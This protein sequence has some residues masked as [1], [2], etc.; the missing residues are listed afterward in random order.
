MASDDSPLAPDGI[1]R[2]LAARRPD[3]LLDALFGPEAHRELRALYRQGRRR[4]GG[5]RVLILPGIMGSTL[6]TR[7]EGRTDT[8]WF[9]PVEIALGRLTRLA[10]PS[11]RRIEPLGVLA[12]TYQRLKLAL[13]A[14]GFDADFHPYD[15]RHSVT[16]AAD[17]LASRLAR[18]AHAR[19]HLV[20]HSLGGLVAR[21][22]LAHPESAAPGRVVLLGTPNGGAYAA[23]QALWGTYPLVRRLARLD[24]AHGPEQLARKVFVTLPGLA[25]LLPVAGDCVDFDPHAAGDWPPGPRPLAALLARARATRLALPAPDGRF[26]LIAGT[27]RDTPTGLR[28]RGDVLEFRRGPEGD[29]TVPLAL[30]R[31]PGLATWYCEAEHGRL[32]SD[33]RVTRATIEILGRGTTRLLPRQPRAARRRARW[34]PDL[35]P[36]PEPKLFWEDLT[37]EERREFLHEFDAPEEPPPQASAGQA[38]AASTPRDAAR[39]AIGFSVGDIADERSEAIVLGLFEN[40][41]PAGAALAVDQRLGGAIAA[42]ARRRALSAQAGG[43]FMLPAGG[44]RLRAG[45]VVFAGLGDFA[46]YGAE[47]QRLAAA[48]VARTLA[49]AGIR[50]YALVLWGTA[51]G[52]AP[53]EAA[54]AQLLGLLEALADIEPDVWPRRVPLVSRSA[55]RLAAA[56]AAMATALARQP[57][58]PAGEL[59]PLPA[60]AARKA[61][62]AAP[63]VTPLS[64]LFVHEQSGELRAALL[65]PTAKG[66]ALAASRKLDPPALS[67]H[68]ATLGEGIG[69]ARVAAFGE[70]LGEL[71]LPAPMRE[72]L[73]TLRET[74]LVIVHDAPASRW[75][76]ETLHVDGWS[77]AAG[78]GLSRRY[79]A[80]GLSVAKWR[81]ERRLD[82]TLPLLLVVNPTGDLAGADEEGARVREL[83][84]R[85]GEAQLTVLARGQATRARLLEAFRSGDY[86]AIHFAGH[87]YFDA[88]APAASGVLC[89]GGR[90]LSGADLAALDAAPALVVF[91]ACESGRVRG[92]TPV[93]R[94]VGRSAGLA[95][96][97]LRGGVGNFV[98]TWWPVSDDAAARFADRL[99]QDLL[100]GRT[101]GAAV[102][103]ARAAV[104]AGRSGDWANY[105]HY[106]GHDFSLKHRERRPGKRRARTR[107]DST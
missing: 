14:A 80:E 76:W 66:T 99:Y 32:P 11:T 29:G 41:D 3:T 49:L 48:N 22:L 88:L 24:L 8:L 47:V 58:A 25:E 101:L 94:S 86:D 107:G 78:A 19:T 56:R 20:A 106:G 53:A 5:E 100:A 72:A 70:R 91:N 18:E 96:A 73:A 82:R 104:R 75:P 10:L 28:R 93:S 64:Y 59:G 74:P 31:W 6:G 89:A 92:G 40:V 60:P 87:A 33:D 71:L 79:A 95:E 83:F 67:R 37:D 52:I 46:R 77:P 15:W 98:G 27:G 12:F 16:E 42:L 34:L 1:D 30:A 105:L 65:G 55:R 13:R 35:P 97:F 36:P 51:S 57:L 44:G 43:V 45:H 85:L 39:T 21:A 9:D 90:V 63:A 84:G 81:E 102:L 26:S 38:A 62:A 54:S 23:A 7:R 2:R 50:E 4:R 17:G 61:A 68:L 103:A 69:I